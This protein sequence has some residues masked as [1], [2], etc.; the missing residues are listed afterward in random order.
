VVRTF[1]GLEGYYRHFIKDFNAIAEPLTKL[2]RKEGFKWSPE[3]EHAF[4]AL[5]HAL[6]Q[7]PM[8]QLLAFDAVFIVQCYAS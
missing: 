3:A 4:T 6:T 2:L 1:L 8:L 5:Q 7:A